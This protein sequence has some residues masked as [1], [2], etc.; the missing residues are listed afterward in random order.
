[1]SAIVAGHCQRCD[2]NY[3][4][5]FGHP[6]WF[7]QWVYKNEKTPQLEALWTLQAAKVCAECNP[8]MYAEFIENAMTRR[9]E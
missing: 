4:Y 7:R 9:T 3:W 5:S 2:S 6:D 1:M 8:E